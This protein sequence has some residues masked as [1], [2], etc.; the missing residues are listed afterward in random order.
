M[1]PLAA[2]LL[3][4]A[5]DRPAPSMSPQDV[6]RTV[7]EA[8]RTSNS[9]APNSGIFTTYRFSSPANHA[10]TGPYGNFLRI[11]KHPDF[12]SL[13]QTGERTYAP[14]EIANG[15]ARQVVTTQGKDGVTVGFEFQLSRQTHEPCQ[16]CWL[17]DGVR[18]IR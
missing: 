11:V 3:L 16:G 10:N 18:R 9:P 13:R 8:L 17:V 12:T 14:M 1:M 15:K 2:G 4:L 6:V 7:V 5:L